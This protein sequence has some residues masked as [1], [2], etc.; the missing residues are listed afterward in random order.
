MNSIWISTRDQD[1]TIGDDNI[2]IVTNVCV[3]IWEQVLAWMAMQFWH[4]A[5]IWSTPIIRE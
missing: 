3:L 2:W 1:G 5:D 4:H